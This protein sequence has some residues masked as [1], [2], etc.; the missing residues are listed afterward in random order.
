MDAE[1]IHDVIFEFVFRES[2]NLLCDPE[3]ID[4]LVSLV[5]RIVLRSVCEEN[6]RC[7]EVATEMCEQTWSAAF[8]N[9]TTRESRN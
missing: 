9:L 1:D 8:R 7:K 3:L 5:Q 6:A 4:D 2:P